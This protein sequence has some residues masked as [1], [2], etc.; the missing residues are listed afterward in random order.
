MLIAN[1]DRDRNIVHIFYRH[2]LTLTWFEVLKEVVFIRQEATM[3]C[4]GRK[5]Y[6][7]C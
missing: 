6:N 1:D 3:Q 4:L 5:N 7:N 2:S